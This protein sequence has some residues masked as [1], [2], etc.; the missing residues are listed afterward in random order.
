MSG[1]STVSELQRL[2][3]SSSEE[4]GPGSPFPWGEDNR[5]VNEPVS[6]AEALARLPPAP[7]EASECSSAAPNWIGHG[8]DPCTSR[9]SY[10]EG[11]GQ[12][13]GR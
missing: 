11:T 1:A 3:S 2:L 10:G 8:A 9:F 7:P 5:E 12:G 4:S 6:L 13:G